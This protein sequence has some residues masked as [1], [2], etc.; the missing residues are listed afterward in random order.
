MNNCRYGFTLI[1]LLIALAVSVLLGGILFST[2]WQISRS[3]RAGED[4]ISVYAKAMRVAHQLEKDISGACIPLHVLY[5]EFKKEQKK[6]SEKKQP[7]NQP[8]APT[9]P[10]TEQPQDKK[11]QRKPL[12]KLFYV[13]SKEKKLELLTCITNNPLTTYWSG[14]AGKPVPKIARVVYRLKPESNN[15]GVAS[16]ALYRQESSDLE[17]G[18]FGAQE[19]K[20]KIREYKMADGI[21]SIECFFT[22]NPST[23]SGSKEEAKKVVSVWDREQKDQQE[24]ASKEKK[25]PDAVQLLLIFWDANFVR[26]SSFSI[27]IPIMSDQRFSWLTVGKEKK[28]DAQPQAATQKPTS[29]PTQPPASRV[30]GSMPASPIFNLPQQIAGMP[31]GTV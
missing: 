23:D 21:K 26:E 7:A 10:K 20:K 17:F 22:I 31:K 8:P 27:A 28:E 6:E 11:Q 19:G 18:A 29:G 3:T 24:D 16:F 12:D 25:L 4:R 2:L 13:V 14:Q 30:P 9:A 1:E 15:A 5:E